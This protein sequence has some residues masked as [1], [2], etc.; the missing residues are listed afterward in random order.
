MSELEERA[1][2]F[3]RI[4]GPFLPEASGSA[5]LVIEALRYSLEAGG[6]RLRPVILIETGDVRSPGSGP[7][8]FCRGIGN[9]TYVFART[10]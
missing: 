5:A 9:D 8:S 4:L 2:E 6:K 1:A 7:L 10:R 3:E